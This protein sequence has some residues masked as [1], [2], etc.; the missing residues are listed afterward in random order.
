[1]AENNFDLNK[2]EKFQNADKLKKE[3]VSEIDIIRDTM[4]MANMF[5]GEPMRIAMKLLEE[6]QTSK[7]SK[8]NE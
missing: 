2:N 3:L 4:V 8:T 1:M 7:P 5:M 6:L